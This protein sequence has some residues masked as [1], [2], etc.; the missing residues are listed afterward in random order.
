MIQRILRLPAV[1]AVRGCSRASHYAQIA[2]G[3]FTPPVKIGLRGS[4]WPE[5]EVEIL[6]TATIAGHTLAEVRILV[7]RLIFLRGEHGKK[8][9]ASEEL[10]LML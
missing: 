1:L 7:Q 10:R 3:L 6:Q 9:L 8:V 5:K 4:G 2:D